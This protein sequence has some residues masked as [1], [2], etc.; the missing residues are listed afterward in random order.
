VGQ[1]A[2][3]VHVL[4]HFIDNR[5][6]VVLLLPSRKGFAFFKNDFFL[7]GCGLPFARYSN[8]IYKSFESSNHL[9]Y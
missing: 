5:G 3:L 9:T 8:L 7:L 4:A 6:E 2:P 1:A